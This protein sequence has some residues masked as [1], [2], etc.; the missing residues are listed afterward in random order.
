MTDEARW[1]DFL[2]LQGKIETLIRDICGIPT[3][4]LRITYILITNV[5]HAS[6]TIDLRLKSPHSNHVLQQQLLECL[7]EQR[8]LYLA[9]LFCGLN[10]WNVD[11]PELP[12]TW[13]RTW[14]EASRFCSGWCLW[15]HRSSYGGH[16]WLL[17]AHLP[18]STALLTKAC[19][20]LLQRQS[21]KCA[22]S[23]GKVL[24]AVERG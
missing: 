18:R 2:W 12:V 22:G 11:S 7:Q 3:A 17:W 8:K 13:T 1:N 16:P 23:A 10:H 21:L 9:I 15:Q 14:T 19:C 6:L 24:R 4:L 20:T 5:F